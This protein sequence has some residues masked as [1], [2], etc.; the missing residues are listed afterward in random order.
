MR[1]SAADGT[2][3]DG[4]LA[5]PAGAR[6]GMVVCHPHP[7]HGG[8]MHTPVVEALFRGLPEGG[9]AVLRFDFRGVGASEGT[10]DGGDAE[11][12]DAAAAVERL[13]EEVSGPILLAGWSF[14]ADVALSTAP[15]RIAGWFAVAPPLRFGAS[16]RGAD[17]RPKMLVVGGR[18]PVAVPDA[19]RAATA[20]WAATVVEELPGA[21]H[22]FLAEGARL[23][24]LAQSATRSGCV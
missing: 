11:R 1:F 18:D 9:I 13:A 20:D 17:P 19:V 21:D 23:V 6:A 4:E 3:L 22:L 15:E 8:S 5:V 2:A 24:E 12:L 7:H 16:P 10:H 14:G